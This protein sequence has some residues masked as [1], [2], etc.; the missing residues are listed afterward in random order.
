MQTCIECMQRSLRLMLK[1]GTHVVVFVVLV[2]RPKPTCMD[3]YRHPS[4]TT[5]SHAHCPSRLPLRSTLPGTWMLADRGEQFQD[6]RRFVCVLAVESSARASPWDSSGGSDAGVGAK[7][8][9]GLDGSS[10]PPVAVNLHQ[11]PQ[12]DMSPCLTSG[13]EA[14]EDINL[15]SGILDRSVLRF[16]KLQLEVSVSPIFSRGVFCFTE[17]QCL[18]Q[19]SAHSPECVCVSLCLSALCLHVSVCPCLSVSVSL[20]ES[21]SVSVSLSVSLYLCVDTSKSG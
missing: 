13:M 1:G 7:A 15:D 3:A 17:C 19:A 5:T 12:V 9:S 4:D 14:L 21:L 20:S 8:S 16:Q 6:T 2:H 11:T 10:A 18:K